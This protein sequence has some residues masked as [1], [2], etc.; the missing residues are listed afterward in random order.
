ML[1]K[2]I[3]QIIFGDTKNPAA[4]LDGVFLRFC[5]II[6]ECIVHGG[7]S[8][9]PTDTRPASLSADEFLIAEYNYLGQAAFQSNEDRARVASFYFV[10]VGTLVAA[11][12]GSQFADGELTVWIYRAFSLL[13]ATLT[14]LGVLTVFQLARLRAAWYSSAKAMNAIKE[15]YLAEFP[16]LEKAI[17]WRDLPEKEKWYSIANLLRLQ[18][19]VLAALTFGA[20]LYTLFRSFSQNLSVWFWGCTIALPL[21]LFVFQRALYFRL[22]KK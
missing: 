12:L 21:G 8:M 18:V 14:I 6:V 4:F 1:M 22:L 13:F 20:C 15:R 5:A 16:V 11:I 3:T 10:S 17:L 2:Y 9:Q 19:T 7:V